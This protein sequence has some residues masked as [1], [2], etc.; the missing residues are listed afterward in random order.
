VCDRGGTGGI[1][2]GTQTGLVGEQAT[3]HPVEQ[4]RDDSSCGTEQSLVEAEGPLEDADE[5]LR[6]PADVEDDDDYGNQHIGQRHDGCQPLRD[7]GHEVHS[8]Q[9]HGSGQQD[10]EHPNHPARQAGDSGRHHLGQ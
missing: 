8:A 6:Q 9:D 4:R 7:P 5:D 2:D 1:G 10:E 3:A